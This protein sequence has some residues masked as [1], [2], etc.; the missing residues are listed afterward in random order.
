MSKYLTINQYKQRDDGML[1][2]S[3]TD[4][5]LAEYISRAE[6]AIDTHM[7]FD[8]RLGGFEPHMITWQEKWDGETL[9]A[10]NPMY[11]VPVRQTV[12]YRVQTSNTTSGDAYAANINSTDVTINT[13]DGYLE[14][15]PLQSVTFSLAP[16]LLNLSLKDPIIDADVNIG[17]YIPFLGDQLFNSGLQT[18]NGPNTLYYAMRG[19]W[20]SS[21]SVALH[22]EPSVLPPVPPVVYK[23]GIGPSFVVSSS[24][25]TL[26][27]T[28]GS[29]LFNSPNQNSDLVYADY[30]AQ[31]PDQARDAC[32]EQVSYLLSKR[33][34][35]QA[36]MYG[37]MM[38]QSGDMRLQRPMDRG[39]LSGTLLDVL[40]PEAAKY[41]NRLVPIPLAG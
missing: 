4:F 35:N 32:V 23:N 8:P 9:R 27:Y 39:K 3:V 40:C 14:I 11:P 10:R 22:L 17:Y 5:A 12:R 13:F 29:V 31:I 41:L 19:F 2:R 30:T 18:A 24:Q 37:L 38:I 33:K 6:T 34:L 28:E 36:G 25:Y 7:G 20:A 1:E 16:I 21:Y 15:V 26:N